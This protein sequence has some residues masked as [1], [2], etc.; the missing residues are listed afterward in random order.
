VVVLLLVATRTS[1]SPLSAP[2]PLPLVRVESMP[3]PGTAPWV[4]VHAGQTGML[5]VVSSPA[6]TVYL[7]GQKLG[8]TPLNAVRVPAGTHHLRLDGAD[9]RHQVKVEITA[10]Q[11]THVR[12][13]W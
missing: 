13:A 2:A 8:T 6:T 3:T 1:A 9:V 11:G 12:V 5:T 10:G 4:D 7:G